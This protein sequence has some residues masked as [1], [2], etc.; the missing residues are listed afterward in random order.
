MSQLSIAP[1]A[2]SAIAA[3]PSGLSRASNVVTVTL[4]TAGQA[5]FAVGNVVTISGSTSV[6]GNDFNGSFPIASVASGQGSLTYLQVAPND[7]GGGGSALALAQFYDLADASIAAGQPLTQAS[8]QALS[9]NA[10]F[11]TVRHEKFTMGY[12]TSGNVVPAP[13]SPVDGYIYS[14]AECI[15][16]PMMVSSR[17]PAG[18]FVPGQLSFPAVASGDIGSGA[19]QGVPYQ[20]YVDR[21]SGVLICTVYFGSSGIVNQGTVLV[22]CDA[23]RWSVNA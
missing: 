8:A 21:T 6:N 10:K 13:V 17:Q 3:S 7:T 20:L 2:S 14:L 9:H 23:Q 12:F 15:F 19:L 22:T 1:L 11:A 16:N 5:G 4:S 18:G